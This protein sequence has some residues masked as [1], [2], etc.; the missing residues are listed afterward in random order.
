MGRKKSQNIRRK[1]SKKCNS[2]VVNVGDKEKAK[3]EGKSLRKCNSMR[4]LI[5]R[6]RGFFFF[7]FFFFPF[8]EQGE[9]KLKEKEGIENKWMIW[10]NSITC[11]FYYELHLG[12]RMYKLVVVKNDDPI[13]IGKL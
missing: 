5:G 1:G 8:L 10:H 11:I 12:S 4:R 2:K 13:M 6:R 3:R 7:F 9:K